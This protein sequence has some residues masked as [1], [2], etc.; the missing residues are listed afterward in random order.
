M[1]GNSW[2]AI[3]QYF[4]AALQPPHL[5]AIAPLEGLSDV[6]REQSIRGG[7][8][9]TPFAAMIAETIIGISYLTVIREVF[10]SWFLRA[11]TG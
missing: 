9:Y 7:I 10:C 5:A 6:F 8:P 11:S 1:A 3:I 4:I 2:L